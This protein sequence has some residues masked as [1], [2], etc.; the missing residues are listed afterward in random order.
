MKS[1]S[2]QFIRVS[3]NA[4]ILGLWT[5]VSLLA[6]NP[7]KSVIPAL[8]GEKWW[9][10]VLMDGDNQPFVDFSSFDL[11]SECHDGQTTP[12]LVSSKGRYVWSDRPFVFSFQDGDLTIDADAPIT[13]IEAGSTLREAYLA[14]SAA[15]FPFD[16]RTPPEE[17]F[18]K[19]Q[20]NNWIESAVFG[21][22][23]KNAEDYVRAIAA[24][25]FPC[26]VVMID[27]GWMVQHGTFRFNPETFPRPIELF[28][29]IH[30]A[31]YKA[32]LW[33]CYFLSP[34]NREG[35]LDYRL[36][37]P[38]K[39]PLLVESTE[40]P[41]EECIVHWWSGKSVSLDLTNPEAFDEFAG[42]LDS[43]RQQ[44]HI[45]GFKFDGGNP[46]Y[47]RGKAK[48]WKP[49][50]Q[51]CDFAHSYNLLGITFPFHEFRAGYRAS[52]LPL[53]VR[54]QDIAPTWQGLES[55]VYDVQLAGLMGCPYTF[56]DMIG[57]GQGGA[58]APGGTYSSKLIVRSC[59]AQTLMPMMQFSVAPW[60][61]L[62]KEECDICRDYA[63]MHV[64][65]SDYIL[66]QVRHAATTGEPIVRTMEYEFPGQ[67][68]DR[69]MSQYMFG[70]RYLV[71][72][73]IR[74][75][76]SVTVELPKG[77]WKDDQGKVFRGPRVLEL[78]NVPLNRLPYYERISK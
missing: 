47:F 11:A 75:D 68:F 8:E 13:P 41:G 27:G 22:N 12:L 15:H 21:I 65:F 62:S 49:D 38:R 51:A 25:G 78:K 40:Y 34:D 77:R 44:Y 20:F 72:P 55:M 63:L 39:K 66:E 76:D 5:S 9:G 69:R 31:G 59:Q 3:L 74:E 70:P 56:G 42:I 29:L 4:F 52:G 6:G 17:M 33:A 2:L 28:D 46:E 67:G 64:A 32:M 61:V 37:Y 16:G 54:L 26:G 57:G 50:M 53:I 24:N 23:Q 45:D 7:V 35:Y 60:R 19:P 1:A 18:C 48:F 73:V 30:D 58:Y 10:A 14:A 43:F 36:K 71:A